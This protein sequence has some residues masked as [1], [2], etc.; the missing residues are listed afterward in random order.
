MGGE[1]RQLRPAI[2]ARS[3]RVVVAWQEPRAGVEQIRL[4]RSTD[5]GATFSLTWLD[6]ATTSAQ[7]EPALALLTDGTTVTAWTDFRAGLTPAVWLRCGSAAPRAVDASTADLTRVKPSQ[8]Q[9]TLAVS[10]GGLVLAWIDYRGGDW[11]V[12]AVAGD[13]CAASP[14]AVRVS[15]SSEREV[16]A[17]DPQLAAA[18]DGSVVL[19]W[20]EIRDRRG[21]ADVAASRLGLTGW[22]GLQAPARV[23][24]GRFRP[25][26][27]FLG[28]GWRV[29]Q[30]DQTPGKNGLT[31]NPLNGTAPARFDDTGSSPNQLWR[32]RVVVRPGAVSAWWCSSTIAPAGAACAPAPSR[33]TPIRRS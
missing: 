20:D 5:R 4:A 1:E 24:Q 26:P 2:A 7:W 10:S 28:G 14:P 19:A 9:P 18:P 6:V 3:G 17:A 31:V 16:L 32:P 30:Q 15:A 25:S 8:L 13:L 11:S 12:Y 27:Y 29:L 23:P 22:S 21:R 33:L